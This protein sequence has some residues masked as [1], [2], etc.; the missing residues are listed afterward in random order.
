MKNFQRGLIDALPV[1]TGY[2]SV[3]FTFA[4]A[5]SKVW[6]SSWLPVA[7]SMMH[8]S[9]TGQFVLL[10]L[11]EA[12]SSIAAIISGIIAINLRYAPM[13]LAIAQRIPQETSSLKR[14]IIATGITDEIVGISL[15]KPAPL[16]FRYF[17]GLTLCSWCGWVGGSI[18]GSNPLTQSLLSERLTQA[19]GIAFPAMFAAIVFPAVRSSPRIRGAV[20]AAIVINIALRLLPL[21]IDP[22]WATLA[23]GILAAIIAAAVH[24]AKSAAIH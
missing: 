12:G 2:F 23:A 4:L 11:T 20:A 14:I 6:D 18:A 15:G 8:L 7:T 22:G 1:F 5:A 9:G 24:P 3:G 10:A 16:P 19:L 13:A 17:L 21:S